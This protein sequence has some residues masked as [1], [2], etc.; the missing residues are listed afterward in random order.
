MITTLKTEEGLRAK[1]YLD[2]RGFLT[3]GY[4]SRIDEELSPEE[5]VLP[6]PR[7]PAS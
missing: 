1:P 2:T 3:V 5:T 6:W 4:G 7:W